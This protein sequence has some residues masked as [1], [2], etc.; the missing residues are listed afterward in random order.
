MGR[1]NLLQ[2]QGRFPI[3]PA[4]WPSHCVNIAMVRS[5]FKFILLTFRLKITTLCLPCSTRVS[6]IVRPMPPVP[7][8]TATVT[9]VSVSKDNY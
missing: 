7:P 8:A 2:G 6:T 3:Q 4:A 1:C 9:I 5:Y